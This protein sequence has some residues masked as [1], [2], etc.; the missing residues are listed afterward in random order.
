MTPTMKPLKD[1]SD[2]GFLR[3]LVSSPTQKI[4]V[5]NLATHGFSAT[6][7]AIRRRRK[8]IFQRQGRLKPGQI[9]T[10]KDYQRIYQDIAAEWRDEDLV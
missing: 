7:P 3:L 1:F 8:M 5:T 2:Y 4:L 6:I 10:A 9:P